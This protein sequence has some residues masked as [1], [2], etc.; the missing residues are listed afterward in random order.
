MTLRPACS[1]SWA[2]R[3]PET[4]PPPQMS[5]WSSGEGVSAASAS[6]LSVSG[7]EEGCQLCAAKGE[8]GGS[9]TAPSAAEADDGGPYS[10][11]PSAPMLSLRGEK[12]PMG[13]PSAPPMARA[14]AT[15]PTPVE[16]REGGEG[17]QGSQVQERAMG[18]GLTDGGALL[19]RRPG[20]HDPE[21]ALVRDRVLL[22]G[23]RAVV[24]VLGRRPKDAV[25][26][27]DARDG[28]A[29]ADDGAGQVAPVER[30]QDGQRKAVV[31]R[32][33]V[34]V[35]GRSSEEQSRNVSTLV[36]KGRRASR[37]GDEMQRERKQLAGVRC[38]ATLA[39]AGWGS[40]WTH[41]G[42]RPIASTRTRTS[43]GSSS[44]GVGMR[45]SE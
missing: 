36:E 6:G 26:D 34:A 3:K 24:A 40:S 25:A 13:R 44:L 10:S 27:L 30:R 31:G 45:A 37:E 28:R 18:T 38:C 20:G 12:G 41:T 23:R 43:V 9:E 2:A 21:R 8:E 14:A 7:S 29:D 16:R 32:L 4:E 15:A 42:L 19:D 39:R 33:P 17:Q 1:A 22:V 5:R 35:E 11:S